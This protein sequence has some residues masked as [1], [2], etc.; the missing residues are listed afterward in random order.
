VAR[1]GD[2]RFVRGIRLERPTRFQRSDVGRRQ[3]PRGSLVAH[4]ISSNAVDS[5]G[6]ADWETSLAVGALRDDLCAAGG[7]ALVA[8]TSK[9]D[10]G[11]FDESAALN[12]RFPNPSPR[13]FRERVRQVGERYGFHVVSVQLLH[14]RELAPIVVVQ[15]DRDRKEFV[16]YVPTIMGLLNPQSRAR[17]QIPTTFEGFFFEARDDRGPFV[18]VYNTLRGATMGGQWSAAGDDVYPYP[19]G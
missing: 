6:L 11:A 1:L 10:G 16:R 18:R 13:V 9:S 17:G 3:P 7:A 4:V 15:T 8:W 19:H 2:H 5:T 14:P 12:Q